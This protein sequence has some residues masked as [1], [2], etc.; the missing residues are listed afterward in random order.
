MDNF[1]IVRAPVGYVGHDRHFYFLD[2]LGDPYAVL[3]D[4]INEMLAGC[5]RGEGSAFQHGDFFHICDGRG[6]LMLSVLMLAGDALAAYPYEDTGYGWPIEVKELYPWENG[7]EAQL[8]GSCIGARIGLFDTLF[9]ANRNGYHL[10]GIRTFLVSGLAYQLQASEVPDDFSED[11]CSYLP[12]TPEDEGGIDEIQFDSCVEEK[13]EA[14]FWGVPL[15]VYTLTLARVGPD[16]FP[17]RLN[18]YFYEPEGAKDF[19][20][21]DRVSGVAWLFGFAKPGVDQ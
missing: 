18:M 11:F 4:L 9:F 8:I 6:G 2:Q 14:D 7:V 20:V 13:R 5:G 17:L 16:E 19:E 12:L 10:G 15:K 1:P 3:N 21:G